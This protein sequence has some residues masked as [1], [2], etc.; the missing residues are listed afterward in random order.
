VTRI[1]IEPRIEP[2]ELRY[3]WAVA[4][5]LVLAA[6]VVV[7]PVPVLRLPDWAGVAL[8]GVGSILVVSGAVRLLGDMDR[9]VDQV[10]AGERRVRVILAAAEAVGPERIDPER[11]LPINFVPVTAGEYLSG[12]AA[13]GSPIA[14]PPQADVGADSESNRTADELL[15][16]ELPIRVLPEAQVADCELPAGLELAEGRF[17]PPPGVRV[18][19]DRSA[20][21]GPASVGI[22]RFSDPGSGPDL[23]LPDDPVVVVDLPRDAPGADATVGLVYELTLPEGAR[24]ARCE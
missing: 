20:V 1:G 16:E 11:V 21:T 7:R 19:I 6:L 14:G 22:A 17:G 23:A 12:V 18:W 4:A 24:A 2:D 5:F 8:V 13:V 15:V 10:A 3:S 9:W